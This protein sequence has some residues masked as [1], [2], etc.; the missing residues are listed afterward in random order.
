MQVCVNDFVVVS[1]FHRD[2]LVVAK[3][4]VEKDL[5]AFFK[6]DFTFDKFSIFQGK[7]IAIFI[8]FCVKIRKI[9]N[10]F[11]AQNNAVAKNIAILRGE[12]KKI[13]AV[14]SPA[15]FMKFKL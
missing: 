6:G 9:L 12:F 1:K 7:N 5:C 3:T 15:A 2:K 13:K 11:T 4:L 14:G 8:C 10:M